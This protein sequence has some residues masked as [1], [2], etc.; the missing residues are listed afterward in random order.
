MANG[1]VIHVSC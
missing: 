1:T